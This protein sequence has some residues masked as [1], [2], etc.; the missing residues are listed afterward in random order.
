MS[1]TLNLSKMSFYWPTDVFNLYIITVKPSR[2][3]KIK[4]N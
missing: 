3:L 1:S 4:C 2:Y